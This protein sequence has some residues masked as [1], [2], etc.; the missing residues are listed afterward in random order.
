MVRLLDCLNEDTARFVIRA[1]IEQRRILHRMIKSIADYPEDYELTDEDF[2]DPLYEQEMERYLLEEP[3]CHCDCEYGQCNCVDVNYID[4]EDFAPP[5]DPR[6]LEWLI[7]SYFP[8]YWK[9]R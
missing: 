2:V 7:H 4:D 3:G 8:A 1:F 5:V 6:A 9:R